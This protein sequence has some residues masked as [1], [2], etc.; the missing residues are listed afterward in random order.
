MIVW[1][2]VLNSQLSIY[3]DTWSTNRWCRSI[4][5]AMQRAWLE[6]LAQEHD[7]LRAVLAWSRT[8]VAGAAIGL[9]LAAILWRFWLSRGHLTEGRIW[10]AEVLARTGDPTAGSGVRAQ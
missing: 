2:S 9:R 8:T 3:S 5:Q 10:L 4:R 6:R 7:N 1:F